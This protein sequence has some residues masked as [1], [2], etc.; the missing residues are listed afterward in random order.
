MITLSRASPT[1]MVETGS[2]SDGDLL[3]GDDPAGV[4]LDPAREAIPG[5]TSVVGA[6]RLTGGANQETW[7]FD[8]VCVNKSVPL[9][10]RRARG[11]ALQRATGIGLDMEARVIQAAYDHG[12]PAPEVLSLLRAEHGIGNGFIMRRIAGETVPRKILKGDAFARVR[13][14]LATQCGRVLAAVHA[15]PT[16]GLGQLNSFSPIARVEWLHEHYRATGQ[17]SPVFSYAFAWLR[18]HAPAGPEHPVLVHGDFRN[19]NLMVDEEGIRAVLDWE[20]AHIGDPAED[21]GWFCIPSWRFGR[22][23]KPAGGFGSKEDLLAGYSDAGGKAP[24]PA[25]LRFWEAYGSLYWGM[26]CARSVNEFRGEADPSVERAMIARRASEAEIDL[27]RLL[28]PR[29]VSHAG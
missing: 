20:N 3:A 9:I 13:P 11:G 26:V 25:R 12:V 2:K 19:G 5:C 10:L 8:A 14:L 24:S 17:V 27:L 6:R 29:S 1:N 15:V 22:L 7:A 18:E 23:D 21:L 4:L 28:A 16:A